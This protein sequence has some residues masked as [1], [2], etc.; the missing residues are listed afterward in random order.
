[1]SHSPPSVS[2]RHL[3][4]RPARLRRT[5][6]IRAS[7]FPFFDTLGSVKTLM[8]VRPPAPYIVFFQLV[9]DL[10]RVP[11]LS[12]VKIA[13]A[14]EPK[15]DVDAEQ[16]ANLTDGC[17][18]YDPWWVLKAKRFAGHPA[19]PVLKA[20][21]CAGRFRFPVKECYFARDLSRLLSVDL[22]GYT[23]RQPFSPELLPERISPVGEK[24][25]RHWQLDPFWLRK[26]GRRV[27][28]A[29]T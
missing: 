13:S 8:L 6:L 9:P 15:S 7:L 24:R 28:G 25:R 23:T 1:M 22:E 16:A 4:R 3:H 26:T 14:L 5:T 29:E 11:W 10:V 12:A 17:W 19:V 20:T 18:H 27:S 21:N 2:A